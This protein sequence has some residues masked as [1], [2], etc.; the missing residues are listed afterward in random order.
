MGAAAVAGQADDA[1]VFVHHGGVPCDLNGSRAQ[2]M[3]DLQGDVRSLQQGLIRHHDGR[4]RPAD[5]D[6]LAIGLYGQAVDIAGLEESLGI[7]VDSEQFMEPFI[8]RIG[9]DA[10][11]E[12][13]EIRSQGD[14]LP[15]DRIREVDLQGVV[16]HP[17]LRLFLRL[18]AG[19]PLVS[20]P[21]EEPFHPGGTYFDIA[22]EDIGLALFHALNGQGAF[23]HPLSGHGASFVFEA[24][25]KG[26]GGATAV[27]DLR[28]TLL[29][30]QE[31]FQVPDGQDLVPRPEGVVL[32]QR[33]AAIPGGQDHGPDLLEFR[34]AVLLQDRLE[35]AGESLHFFEANP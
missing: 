24:G 33:Q 8:L 11:V 31:F 16:Q 5:I 26:H 27:S 9:F 32:E 13:E 2:E 15:E 34:L 35:I 4:S 29:V 21:G 18:D 30:I 19:Y 3:L 6:T 25:E 20:G 12:D 7:G 1:A 22:G 17:G 14:V 28:L 10:L 23:E